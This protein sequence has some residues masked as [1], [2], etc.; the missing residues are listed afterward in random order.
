[1]SLFETKQIQTFK[2][3]QKVGIILQKKFYICGYKEYLQYNCSKR[4]SKNLIKRYKCDIPG[5]ISTSCPQGKQKKRRHKHRTNS[6]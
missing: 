1:M 4:P 3:K 6:R 5:H 2:K